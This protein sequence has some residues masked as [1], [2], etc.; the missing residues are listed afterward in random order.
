[1][2]SDLGR[3]FEPH[4]APD[5]VSPGSAV[6]CRRDGREAADSSPCLFDAG[7]VLPGS[8]GGNDDALHLAAAF[9][10]S[11]GDAMFA[12]RDRHPEAVGRSPLATGVRHVDAYQHLQGSVSW[13]APR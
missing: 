6:L 7:Y 13:G 4:G 1:V 10:Q 9:T 11:G 12:L 2:C 5:P 3:A 8:D